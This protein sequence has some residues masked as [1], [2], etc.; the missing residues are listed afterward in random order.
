MP[1]REISNEERA[2]DLFSI[3]F[4]GKAKYIKAI[5]WLIH[6]RKMQTGFDPNKQLAIDELLI[7]KRF[8]KNIDEATVLS[9]LFDVCS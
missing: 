8:A 7:R 9:Q 5:N 4:S 1:V 6:E 2:A 3:Y